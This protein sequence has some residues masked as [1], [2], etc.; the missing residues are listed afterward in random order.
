MFT[1]IVQSIGTVSS[2]GETQGAKRLRVSAALSKNL[3]KGASVAVNG[4]CLTVESIIETEIVVSLMPQTCRSTTLGNLQEG[5][6]VN[7]EPSLQV[8]DEIGGHFVFGHVDGVGRISN[9]KPDGEAALLSVVVSEKL[10]KFFA[11][12]GS[13]ALDGVSLTI[14]DVSDAT[15]TVSLVEHTLKNTTFGS[16]QEGDSINVEVDMLAR[17]VSART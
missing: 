8:G 11:P 5:S 10:L 15:I 9:L 12:K 2:I 3:M 17:Y 1:G 7:I 14:V 16:K 13:V 4:V 6:T